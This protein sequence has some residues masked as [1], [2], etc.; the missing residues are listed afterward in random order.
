MDRKLRKQERDLLEAFEMWTR[1]NLENMSWKN[2]TPTNM[3]LN[4]TSIKFD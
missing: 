4:Q 2:Q 1:L 3:C